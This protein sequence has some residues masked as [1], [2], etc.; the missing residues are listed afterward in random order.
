[1]AKKKTGQHVSY[2]D[3]VRL[4]SDIA[5]LKAKTDKKTWAK[6]VNDA[7]KRGFSVRG[8]LSNVPDPLKERTHSSL[9]TEAQKSVAASYA[10]DLADLDTQQGRVASLDAK[11][12][13]DN[14]VFQTWLLQQNEKFDVAARANQKVYQDYQDAKAPAAQAAGDAAQAGAVADASASGSGTDFSQATGLKNL[15]ADTAKAV[16]TAA[17]QADFARNMG[18]N[19]EAFRGMAQ[20]GALAQGVTAEAAR[21]NDTAKSNAAITDARNKTL[22]ARA[23]DTIKEYSRLLDGEITKATSNRDYTAAAQQLNLGEAKFN[24]QVTAR[25]ADDARADKALTL[26]QYKADNIKNYQDAQNK[27]GYDRIK[28]SEGKSSADRKLRKYLHDHPVATPKAPGLRTPQTPAEL[29]A[30]K[31]D[32]AHAVQRVETAKT[33]LANLH[34]GH[35][36]HG[37]PKNR[38]KV[39]SGAKSRFIG[40]REYLMDQGYSTTEIDVANDLWAHQGKLSPA[41]IKKAHLLQIRVGE[42]GYQ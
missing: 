10:P 26:D 29:R 9:K 41:G 15:S 25:K 7:H 12:Q 32:S 11:R 42:A 6:I 30:A 8:A 16:G 20:Q 18:A 14:Q 39:W 28:S 40:Y 33:T 36:A 13:A 34:A 3:Q 1:M 37:D 31:G 23:A 22:A 4:G 19:M 35:D 5:A 2:A 17:G 38:G 24:E 27:I 21:M